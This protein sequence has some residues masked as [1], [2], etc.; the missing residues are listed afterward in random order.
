MS[1][2]DRKIHAPKPARRRRNVTGFDPAHDVA[3]PTDIT[4]EVHP[5]REYDI[6]EELGLE[7]GNTEPPPVD[8]R[9]ILPSE[10]A[11]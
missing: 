10:V 2:E 11:D 6:L 9:L 1:A 7:S 3:D 4:I 5:S 8:I